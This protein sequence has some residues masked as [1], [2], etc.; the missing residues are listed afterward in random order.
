MGDLLIEVPNGKSSS[1][2]VL[3]NVLYAPDLGL[4][5]VSIGHIVKAGYTVEFNQGCCNIKQKKDGR[6]I[7]S[8]P[9]GVS[10]LYKVDHTLSATFAAV[11]PD[12]PID[13]ITLHQRL[14]HIS[15]DSIRA[16]VR[17]NAVAG[18]KSLTTNYLSSVIRVNTP[19]KHASPSKRSIK[20]LLCK[21]LAMRSTQMSGGLHQLSA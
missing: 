4:T 18:C 15:T 16:F 5:I 14:S 6:R 3:C 2:I 13:I 12:E 7:A 9:A 19:R 11:I 1:K 8:I 17:A 20:P 10:G 21:H